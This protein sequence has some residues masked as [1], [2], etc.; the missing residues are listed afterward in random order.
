LHTYF[1]IGDIGAIRVRGL[2]G[3][4]YVDSAGGG[5]RKRQ[6]GAVS[7][8]GEVDRVYLN[9]EAVCTIADPLL[10]RC[11]EI[12]KTGSRS[13]VVWNPWDQK[14]ARFADLG[15]APSAHGGWRQMVCIE[16]ANALDNQLTIA[17]GET[18]RLAVQYR[19]KKM[20]AGEAGAHAG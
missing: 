7:F 13:T 9:T 1:Q 17:P 10:E 12:S 8:A 19:V 14:A 11:I 18:H 3:T 4:E 15:G 5:Q 2:D 16:S 6:A 20:P